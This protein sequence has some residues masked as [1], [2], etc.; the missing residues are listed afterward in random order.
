MGGRSGACLLHVIG[1]DHVFVPV[2][3]VQCMELGPPH[4]QHHFELLSIGLKALVILLAAHAWAV[5][6]TVT[7]EAPLI[8]DCCLALSGTAPSTP[9]TC[10]C[11]RAWWCAAQST[12]RACWRQ[13]TA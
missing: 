11:A 9:V 10:C 5:Y 1:T 2:A 12:S 3:L 7:A 6:G 8:K 13:S 4:S